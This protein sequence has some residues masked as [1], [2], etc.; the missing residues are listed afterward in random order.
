MKSFK[1]QSRIDWHNKDR[2]QSP[3]LEDIQTGAIQRIADATERM[4]GN[5]LQLQNEL[6]HYKRWNKNYREENEK[7]RRSI[8]ALQG[9]ITKLKKQR[10]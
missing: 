8:S 7:L 2:Q 10:K 6:D 9:V 3:T 1:E 4:A 5:Y